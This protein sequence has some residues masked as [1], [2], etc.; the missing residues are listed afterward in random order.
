MSSRPRTQLYYYVS[1]DEGPKL[2]GLAP[3]SRALAKLVKYCHQAGKN[4]VE[5]SELNVGMVRMVDEEA[6]TMPKL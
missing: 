4:G 2:A 6:E 5:L 1:D 3:H